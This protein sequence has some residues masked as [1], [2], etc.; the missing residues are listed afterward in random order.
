[1]SPIPII[2]MKKYFI[3]VAKKN[4]K[5]LDLKNFNLLN[6]VLYLESSKL[7]T[8]QKFL[9][10]NFLFS[11]NSSYEIFSITEIFETSHKHYY[12]KLITFYTLNKPLK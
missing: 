7:R 2:F 10:K 6:Y 5:F 9:S 11:H 3:E 8:C 12:L 4:G 1:M